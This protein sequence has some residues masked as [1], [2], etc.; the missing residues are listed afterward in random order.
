MADKSSGLVGKAKNGK[1]D[2]KHDL[3][4]VRMMADKVDDAYGH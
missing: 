4:P 2:E 1:D 3:Q